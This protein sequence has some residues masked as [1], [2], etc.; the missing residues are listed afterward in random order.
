MVT[1]VAAG[2][3][4][5]LWVTGPHRQEAAAGDWTIPGQ[6]AAWYPASAPFQAASLHAFEITAIQ[7][8]LLRIAAPLITGAG[9]CCTTMG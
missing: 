3:R 1:G 8:V 6:Q 2:T 9:E 4:R 7:K 5:Q